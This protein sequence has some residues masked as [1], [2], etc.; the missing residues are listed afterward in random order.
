MVDEHGDEPGEKRPPKRSRKADGDAADLGAAG[1]SKR[2]KRPKRRTK[3]RDTGSRGRA[4]AE[5]ALRE[6]GRERGRP[7]ESLLSRLLGDGDPRTRLIGVGGLVL[8]I[9]IVVLYGML[10]HRAAQKR[11]LQLLAEVAEQNPAVARLRVLKQT[12]AD[13]Q[14]WTEL[15]WVELDPS[16]AEGNE[17]VVR[18]PGEMIRVGVAQATVTHRR[19]DEPL[20]AM[21]FDS[22]AA[23]GAEDLRLAPETGP[24][25]FVYHG[26][27][28]DSVHRTARRLWTGIEGDKALPGY[29]ELE[30][31]KLAGVDLA[32]LIGEEW[33]LVLSPTGA[34]EVRRLRSPLEAYERFSTSTPVTTTRGLEVTIEE[35]GRHV[36]FGDQLDPDLIFWRLQVRVHNGSNR[37]MKVDPNRFQLQDDRQNVFHPARSGPATLGV[38]QGQTLRLRFLVPP[39]SRAMRFTIP[40][41][42]TASG[43]SKQPLVVFLEREEAYQGDVASVGD[44]LATLTTVERKIGESGFE[45]VAYLALANTTWDVRTLEPEQFTLENLGYESKDAIVA[46]SVSLTEVDPFLPEQLAVTFLAGDELQRA[47][48]RMRFRDARRKVVHEEAVFVLLPLLDGDAHAEG[49]RAYIRQT[50]GGEQYHKYL[51]L[52]PGERKGVLGLLSDVKARERQALYHLGL[53]ERY[54]PESQVIA[55]AR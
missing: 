35:A 25:Y 28:E 16:G 46:A 53:A 44:F 43:D 52:A 32:M 18:L 5:E 27:R 23:E 41:E 39:T 20:Q 4:A 50:C 13:G 48:M 47:D 40:G 55:G 7:G 2:P 9:L 10:S 15:R 17:Q 19:L 36:E 49:G 24:H 37:E 51:E 29:L 22:L 33:E 54:F 3:P 42:K 38:G 31:G 26:D 14:V 8:V 6:P 21:Y 12:A 34:V 11:N 45:V 1:A 30:R